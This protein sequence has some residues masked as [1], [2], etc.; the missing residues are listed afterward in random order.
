MFTTIRL[1]FFIKFRKMSINVH[2]SWIITVFNCIVNIGHCITIISNA[3]NQTQRVLKSQLRTCSKFLTVDK[4]RCFEDG[5]G[6]ELYI[7]GMFG[8][9]IRIRTPMELY[10]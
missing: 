8:F 4:D 10:P 1:H 5:S 9:Q 3:N 7:D 6:I 2:D